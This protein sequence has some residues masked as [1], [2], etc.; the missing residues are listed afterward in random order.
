MASA[1]Y[2]G[3]EAAAGWRRLQLTCYLPCPPSPQD[4]LLANLTVRFNNLDISSLH[5]KKVR[6]DTATG[7]VVS[8]RDVDAK[9]HATSLVR[10][11]TLAASAVGQMH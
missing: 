5:T 2:V 6:A 10:G 1:A 11:T 7:T 9:L 8:S 4:D 3:F